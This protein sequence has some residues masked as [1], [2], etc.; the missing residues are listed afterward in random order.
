MPSLDLV[1]EGKHVPVN[2]TFI[3]SVQEENVWAVEGYDAGPSGVP[4]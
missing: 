2:E 4:Q 1:V 3:S